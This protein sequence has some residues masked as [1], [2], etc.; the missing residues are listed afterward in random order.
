[1]DEPKLDARCSKR[2]LS[3]LIFPLYNL[4]VV[5][6]CLTLS[7]K[8]CK[9]CFLI[10]QMEKTYQLMKLT[11]SGEKQLI[12]YHLPHPSSLKSLSVS[13][14]KLLNLL[15]SYDILSLKKTIQKKIHVSVWLLVVWGLSFKVFL[16]LCFQVVPQAKRK[17]P[18]A[19]LGYNQACHSQNNNKGHS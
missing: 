1:M 15:Y 13:W 8:C 11:S 3:P 14:P 18:F 16:L 5:P 19:S 10:S 6:K 17:G 12:K 9:I 4:H 7:A 2:Q